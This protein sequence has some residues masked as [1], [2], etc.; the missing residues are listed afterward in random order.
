[1]TQAFQREKYKPCPIVRRERSPNA[2]HFSTGPPSSAPTL[3]LEP[4]K[5]HTAV[6]ILLPQ[7]QSHTG[8]PAIPHECRGRIW[9]TVCIQTTG[10]S[11]SIT[12]DLCLVM[13][14]LLKCWKP[15]LGR[16]LMNLST[17]LW[18]LF[19]PHPPPPLPSR[20]RSLWAVWSCY[21]QWVPC[22]Q[23][24]DNLFGEYHYGISEV[25]TRRC[26]SR[27]S[28]PKLSLDKNGNWGPEKPR[29]TLKVSGLHDGRQ[30]LN[31]TI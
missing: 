18:G 14:P 26:P 20:P 9:H 21:R 17:D 2:Q 31:K 3:A 19:S 29:E 16:R 6:W 1:M 7:I 12:S 23:W 15:S 5:E 24:T 8:L 10:A 11:G 27:W 13:V 4:E 22:P 28:G 30:G 25:K